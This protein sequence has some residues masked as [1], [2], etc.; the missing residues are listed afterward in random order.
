MGLWDFGKKTRGE[1]YSSHHGRVHDIH[2][3]SDEGNFQHLA[4]VAGSFTLK[5]IFF[6]FPTLFL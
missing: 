6:P 1:V 4:N 2:I 3:I 5:L